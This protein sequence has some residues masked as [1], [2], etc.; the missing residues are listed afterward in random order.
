[1]EIVVP[2]QIWMLKVELLDSEEWN[3]IFPRICKHSN[4][5]SHRLNVASTPRLTIEWI[6]PPLSSANVDT[7]MDC[8]VSKLSCVMAWRN[9][10]TLKT[11]GCY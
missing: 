3:N 6:L 9:L 2:N 4:N 10:W 5:Y 7:D 11:V 8:R 1:M